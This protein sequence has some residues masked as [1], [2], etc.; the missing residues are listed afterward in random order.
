MR[1]SFVF[2]QSIKAPFCISERGCDIPA[3]SAGISQPRSD[4]TSTLTDF[5]VASPRMH[6]HICRAD[7]LAPADKLLQTVCAPSGDPC[8]GKDRCE[9]LHR[10]PEHVVHEPAVKIDVCADALIDLSFGSYDAGSESFYRR[11]E[12]KLLFKVLFLRQFFHKA[13]E[14]LGAG[15][16]DGI[17]R[18][19]DAVNKPCAVERVLVQELLR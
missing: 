6:R 17:N 7:Y 3:K 19:T 12:G 15:I 4:E 13:A 9:K 5:F 16:G 14:Y 18:V 1:C 10:K 2:L 8:D 11:V